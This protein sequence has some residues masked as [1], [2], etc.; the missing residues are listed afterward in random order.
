MKPHACFTVRAHHGK[1]AA[2]VQTGTLCM[3]VDAGSVTA[4]RRL[5]ARVCGDALEYIRIALRGHEAG[6]QMQVWLCVSL[7]WVG[8]LRETIARQLQGVEFV[9]TSRARGV[10]A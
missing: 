7:P 6:A 4:L 9:E 10:R 8:L 5:A 2:A 1:P 3:T